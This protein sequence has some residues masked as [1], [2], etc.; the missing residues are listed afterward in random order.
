[1][2][3]SDLAA[4]LDMGGY[5][6]YVWGS[7]AMCGAAALWEAVLLVHRRRRALEDLRE[8]LKR[9]RARVMQAQRHG[10]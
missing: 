6:L 5:A 2:N 4:F 3:D 8:N 10:A 1:V 7:F 9:A